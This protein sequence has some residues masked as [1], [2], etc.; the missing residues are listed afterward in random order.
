[1]KRVNKSVMMEIRLWIPRI[2]KSRQHS[3]RFNSLSPLALLNLRRS[4]GF[5]LGL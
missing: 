1:M 4:K 3:Q 5:D 2:I